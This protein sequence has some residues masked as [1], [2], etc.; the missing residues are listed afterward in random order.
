MHHARPPRDMM[1]CPA[2][3]TSVKSAGHGDSHVVHHARKLRI[4]PHRVQQALVSVLEVCASLANAPFGDGSLEGDRIGPRD[5]GI[6]PA[7]VRIVH[8][9]PAR[10]DEVSARALDGEV[11]DGDDRVAAADLRDR[12]RARDALRGHRADGVALGEVAG[13]DP[14][15]VGCA[16]LRVERLDERDGLGVGAGVECRRVRS[17]PRD[18]ERVLAGGGDGG[19]RSLSLVAAARLARVDG[20]VVDRPLEEPRGRGGILPREIGPVNGGLQPLR[21]GQ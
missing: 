7:S 8:H 3:W 14:A 9:H 5:G 13:G 10:A 6:G 2:C 16:V 21:S 19:R 20:D 18:E 4:S 15:A 1:P 17:R 11:V 12:G